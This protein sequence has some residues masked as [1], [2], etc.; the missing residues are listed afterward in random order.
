ML[1]MDRQPFLFSLPQSGKSFLWAQAVAWR[2]VFSKNDG[3]ASRC[4]ATL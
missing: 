2:A 3:T 1:N 4:L